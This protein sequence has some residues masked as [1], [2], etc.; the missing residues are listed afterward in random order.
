MY[1]RKS[2]GPRIKPLR[3]NIINGLPLRRIP[4]QKDQK[5]SITNKWW[6]KAKTRLE[7]EYV[8]NLWRRP[9]GQTLTK[10]WI[11]HC[12]SSRSPNP[13]K[14]PRHSFRYNYLNVCVGWED[15]NPSWKSE[16]RPHFSICSTNL[17]FKSF[18]KHLLTT[19]MRLSE[20]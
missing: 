10:P 13:N 17:L 16:K 8:L 5:P 20:Q 9:A 4:I 2:L 12:Y 11:Y 3:S 15:K 1:N 7:I 6:N 19:E 14:Y 18:S